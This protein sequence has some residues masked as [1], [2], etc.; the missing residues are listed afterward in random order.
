[1]RWLRLK[2]TA[3]SLFITFISFSQLKISNNNSVRTD[4]QKIVADFPNNF[5]SVKGEVIQINPQT[6]EYASKVRIDNAN[7]S[8]TKYSSNEKKVYSW[9]ATILST[10]NFDEATKKYKWLYEQLKGMNVTY[11]AHQ[12]SLKGNY[13]Q[14]EEERKFSV[15]DFVLSNSGDALQKLRIEVSMQFEFPE[16]KVSMIVYQRER[17][18]NEGGKIK[19]GK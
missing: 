1:M 4:L 5:N 7:C 13:Q 14:P 18:D 17:E 11:G 2:L 19:E 9:Q 10:E 8:V 16:W 6:T 12:Y 3:S 15:S